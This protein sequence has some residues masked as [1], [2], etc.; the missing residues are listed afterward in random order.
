MEISKKKNKK[1][2]IILDHFDWEE[3][4]LL[5]VSRTSHNRSYF[6][7]LMCIFFL[8]LSE[9]KSC[10]F[11]GMELTVFK[12]EELVQKWQEILGPSN[13][14]VVSVVENC[15]SVKTSPRL[16]RPLAHRVL[17]SPRQVAQVEKFSESSG[18]GIS[19][20]ANSGHHYIRSVLPEG[21]VGRCGKLFSGDELLEVR[22]RRTQGH[23][24][25]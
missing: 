24:V 8:R 20:E 14:V 19:L 16:P 6:K 3:D 23:V 21:P 4:K 7:T 5:A 10:A 13:E 1:Q 12:E 22:P 9:P 18:L 17:L 2:N 15:D 11:S 25:K